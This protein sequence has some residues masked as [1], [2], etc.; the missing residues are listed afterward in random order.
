VPLAFQQP[1]QPLEPFYG[2]EREFNFDKEI[3]PILD[4]KCVSCHSASTSNGI[5][6]SGTKVGYVAHNG[7][8]VGS[9]MNQSYINLTHHNSC[10]NFSKYVSWFSAEDS[11][12]LHPPYRAGSYKS[13]LDSMLTNGHHNVQ[14]TDQQMRTIRCWI[15]LGVPMWGRYQEGHPGAEAWLTQRGV[16]Q[17]I[18]KTN[19][20]AYIKDFPV[21]TIPNA[22]GHGAQGATHADSWACGVS[23]GH[24]PH[25]WFTVPAGSEMQIVQVRLYDTRGAL[26]ST[27][28]DKA[29]TSGYHTLTFTGRQMRVRAGQY[30][31][32]IQAR[33]FEKSFP[34]L[35]IH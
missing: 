34:I 18:E 21:A 32:K 2:P 22:Q 7:N 9:P 27:I 6:L 1:P 16:W 35:M 26:L 13:H 8:V 4:A 23:S 19:I 10:D 33:G 17:G 29:V 15:D 20:A 24:A 11:P 31:V 14:M 5:D 30:F 25:V 12:I 3:Q 28:L